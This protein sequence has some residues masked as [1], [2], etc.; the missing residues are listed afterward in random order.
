MAAPSPALS[1]LVNSIEA[2]AIRRI[3]ALA[4]TLKDPIDLSIGMPHFDTPD[5]VKEAAIGAIRAGHNKY[6]L[7]GG[8]P[9]LREALLKRWQDTY[10]VKQEAALITGGCC[11]SL[12]VALLSTINPGDEVLLPDPYF[13]AYPQL[14][15]IAQGVPAYYEAMGSAEAVVKSIE[16][17]LTKRTKLL[18]IGSPSN[19]TGLVLPKAAIQ[20]IVKTAQARGVWVLSDEIYEAFVFDEAHFSAGSVDPNVIVVGSFSK[21]HSMTGWRIGYAL[22]P[23]PVVE[24][25]IKLQQF[26]FVNPPSP[27]QHAALA[28]LKTPVDYA[29]RE[30]KLLRDLIYGGLIEKG[31]T[32]QKPGGAFY[33]FPEVPKGSGCKTGAEFCE[34]A[35]TKNMLMVPGCAFS[36]KDTHFRISYATSQTKLKQAIQVLGDLAAGK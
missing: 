19:P 23:T 8:I 27:F 25:M 36:R 24:A 28:A 12:L 21:S 3:F 6:T 20:A 10:G 26:T 9:P 2:S 17:A 31:Y 35:I 4:V 15:K 34:K 14:V 22:G 5:A 29:A 1:A 32:V 30:Y 13:V 33:I 16:K 18:V 11:G 7:S